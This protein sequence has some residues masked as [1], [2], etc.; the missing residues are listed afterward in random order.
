LR[1]IF[2]ILIVLLITNIIVQTAFADDKILVVTESW[3]PYNYLDKTGGIVGKSTEVVKAVLD[4]TGL[5]YA[6]EMNPWSRAFNIASSQANVLIYSILRTPDRENFFHWICPISILEQHKVYKLSSRMD[7]DVNTEQEIKKYTTGVTDNTF[8]H[9]YMSN[10][11][12]VDGENLQVNS[13]DSVSIKMFLAGRIDL[14]VSLE[15]SMMRTLIQKGLDTS[16]VSPLFTLPGKIYPPNCMALSKQTPINVVN[17]IRQA[18]HR[19]I[20]Q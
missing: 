11:G 13:D 18:H 6:I 4:D 19:F 8:L 3:Y 12:F 1:N 16:I 10:L 5:D 9:K 2:L 14:L 7:V 17:K 20:S 15:S